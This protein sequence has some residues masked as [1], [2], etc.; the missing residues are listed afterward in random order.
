MK[1]TSKPLAISAIKTAFNTAVFENASVQLLNTLS[2]A[3]HIAEQEFAPKANKVLAVDTRRRPVTVNGTRFASIRDAARFTVGLQKNYA[4][5]KAYLNA[6]M[7]ES[8]K[9]TN[10]CN[11]GKAG[12]SWA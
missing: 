9:I 1:P 11:K 6:L 3:V 12:Y 4:N 2:Q 7:N 5:K 10:R 8:A